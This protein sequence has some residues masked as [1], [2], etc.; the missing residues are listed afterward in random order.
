MRTALVLTMVL[1]A[2]G[3]RAAEPT[4][5]EASRLVEL[6]TV[7]HKHAQQTKDPKDYEAAA[8]LYEKYFARPVHPEEP[9]MSF[10]FAELLFN[11][12]R[13]EEAV[14]PRCASRAA[15]S[16]CTTRSASARC[17]RARSRAP[18]SVPL[19]AASS[20]SSPSSSK[21]PPRFRSANRRR[22]RRRAA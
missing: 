3:V 15:R 8:A 17:G 1:C 9:A 14:P 18:A 16:R 11:Q 21:A 5:A 4:D 13:Y 20:A 7:A 10:Y 12:Q 6:A 22:R 19:R 2:G